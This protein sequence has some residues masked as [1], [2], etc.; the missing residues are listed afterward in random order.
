M[1]FTRN[2]SEPVRRFRG[3]T[4]KGGHKAPKWDW[5]SV[6]YFGGEVS[7]NALSNESIKITVFEEDLTTS[8]FV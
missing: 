3:P 1:D 8:D 4:H 6:L 5:E 2:A 7:Q